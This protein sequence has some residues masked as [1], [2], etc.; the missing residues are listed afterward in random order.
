MMIAVLWYSIETCH[1]II[2][3]QEAKQVWK[4]IRVNEINET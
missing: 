1:N 2:L 4:F 3:Q